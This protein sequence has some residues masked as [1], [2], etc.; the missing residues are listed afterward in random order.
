MATRKHTAATHPVVSDVVMTTNLPTVKSNE[1][2][3]QNVPSAQETTQV[4][5]KVVL[6]TRIYSMPKNQTLKVI[7]EQITLKLFFSMSN[8]TIHQMSLTQINLIILTSPTLRSL[9][10][11]I[12][13]TQSL[14]PLPI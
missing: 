13:I 7:M 2:I 10:A 9:Q 6:S 14:L 4:V 3:H 11:V 1:K 8:I 12:Q 5:T